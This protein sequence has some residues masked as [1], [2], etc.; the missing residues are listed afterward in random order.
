VLV[1]VSPE[2]QKLAITEFRVEQPKHN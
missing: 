1:C 2:V